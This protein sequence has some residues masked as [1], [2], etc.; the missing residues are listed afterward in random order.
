LVFESLFQ[1][2]YPVAT[3]P[4]EFKTHPTIPELEAS[5]CGVVRCKND[6]DKVDYYSHK[7]TAH[8]VFECWSGSE[9]L[10]YTNLRYK[11]LNVYD[12]SYEN[13]EILVL[14]CPDRIAKEKKFM[15]NT[16]DQ[17]LIRE[18]LFGHKRDM[19]DY[20]KELGIAQRYIKAWQKVSP[21]HKSKQFK[22]EPV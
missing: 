18:E 6:D 9:L 14:H 12:T 4:V 21:Q 11:N 7:S 20:F 10:P 15:E 3:Y 13:L 2:T 22:G 19:E 5:Y 8:I 17:M 1:C 16:V